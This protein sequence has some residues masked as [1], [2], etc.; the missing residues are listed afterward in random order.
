[1][2]ENQGLVENEIDKEIERELNRGESNQDK[3]S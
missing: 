1:M 3:K 2:K